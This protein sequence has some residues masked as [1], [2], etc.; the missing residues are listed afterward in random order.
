MYPAVL[1]SDI[2]HNVQC[3]NAVLVLMLQLANLALK[4]TLQIVIKNR[5]YLVWAYICFVL[6]TNEIVRSMLIFTINQLM[7]ER[8]NEC[9]KWATERICSFVDFCSFVQAKEILWANV[10]MSASPIRE[11]DAIYPISEL[12]HSERRCDVQACSVRLFW[13]AGATLSSRVPVK[14]L[15]TAADH[16]RTRVRISKSRLRL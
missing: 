13:S 8:M 6:M 5:I 7:H 10:I 1:I 11:I 3:I 4:G 14:S 16:R 2:L 9:K 12:T 15:M